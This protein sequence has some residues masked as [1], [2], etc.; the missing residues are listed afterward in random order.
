[1][2]SVLVSF[3]RPPTV[4]VRDWRT[5]GESLPHNEFRLLRGGPLW[6]IDFEVVSDPPIVAVGIDIE[7]RMPGSTSGNQAVPLDR[8][9][10]A[11]HAPYRSRPFEVPW[12]LVPDACISAL[13]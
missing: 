4:H 13:D 10:I 2:L 12:M 6:S 11:L 9:H 1:M 7:W 5:A 3:L 8:R